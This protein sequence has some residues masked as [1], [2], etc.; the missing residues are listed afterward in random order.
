MTKPAAH[1]PGALPLSA[2]DPPILMVLSR[3]MEA[4]WVADESF[5]TLMIRRPARRPWQE[6]LRGERMWMS[7]LEVPGKSRMP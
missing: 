3:F 4:G 5:R 7:D 2:L 1:N 6:T